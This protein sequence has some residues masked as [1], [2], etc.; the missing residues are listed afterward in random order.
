MTDDPYPGAAQGGASGTNG[1]IQ[2]RRSES[3]RM[4]SLTPAMMTG[5]DPLDLEHQDLVKTINQIHAAEIGLDKEAVRTWLTKFKTDL[6]AHFEAEEAYLET[7]AY[8]AREA[9]AKHHADTVTALDRIAA[10]LHS[11]ATVTGGIAAQCF[12]GLLQAVLTMDM[13]FL[14]WQAERAYR[15]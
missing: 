2:P 1:V 5:I 8:P 13:R 4:Y 15:A 12:D 3:W 9:H 11:D 10:T 7:L 6:V 14:N